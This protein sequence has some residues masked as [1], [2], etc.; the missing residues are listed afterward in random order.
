M[1]QWRV[2]A[3]PSLGLS[4]PQPRS[5]ILEGQKPKTAELPLWNQSLSV[6]WS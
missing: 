6:P 4:P 2:V 5:F 1:P 3:L